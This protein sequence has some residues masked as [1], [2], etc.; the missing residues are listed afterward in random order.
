MLKFKGFKGLPGLSPSGY[1]WDF[2]HI[3]AHLCLD[4]H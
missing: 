1:H 3:G 2:Y 4:D